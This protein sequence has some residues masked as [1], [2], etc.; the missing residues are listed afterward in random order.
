MAP[1]LAGLEILRLRV[2]VAYAVEMRQRYRING[3]QIFFLVIR[4]RSK[5][6]CN[7]LS[8][9]PG[10]ILSDRSYKL[11]LAYKDIIINPSLI[12]IAINVYKIESV[13]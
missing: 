9:S 10:E 13:F 7:C 3:K 5:L 6:D 11:L 2:G 1:R 12:A 8:I 4:L